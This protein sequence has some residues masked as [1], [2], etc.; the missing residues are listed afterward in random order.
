M[1][2]VETAFPAAASPTFCSLLSVPAQ[3]EGHLEQER[4]ALRPFLD[5]GPDKRQ[6]CVLGVE[7]M[8]LGPAICSG[9]S[10]GPPG[11]A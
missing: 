10:S 3:C 11:H 8:T 9:V 6:P 1:N 7:G 2:V 4:E 5:S